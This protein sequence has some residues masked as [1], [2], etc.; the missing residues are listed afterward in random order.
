MSIITSSFFNHD[1]FYLFCTL[2]ERSFVSNWW[3]GW[4]NFYWCILL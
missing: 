1:M 4:A 2:P 3:Y